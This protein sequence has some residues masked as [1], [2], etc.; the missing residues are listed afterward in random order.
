MHNTFLPFGSQYFRAPTPLRED[1]EKDLVNFKNQGFNTIKIWAQWR[2]NN[3]QEGVYLF[4]DL[5]ELLDLSLQNGIK[6]IINIILDVAPAWFYL[7]YPESIMLQADGNYLVPQVTEYRQVGGAPGPCYHNPDAI[8]EKSL[9]VEELSSKFADHPALLLWDL[10]NEP[11]LTCG[12][13]REAND[14]SMVCY[15]SA[16][17]DSFLKWLKEK[18]K[19]IHFL[20]STWQRNYNNFDEV[21]LPRNS[22][23]FRD[24]ID[25]RTFF[26]DTLAADLKNRVDSVK[27]FDT[28]HPVMIHTVPPPYFNMINAC[29]DDYKM[30][31]H[32]DLFGNSI[33]SDPFPVA[34]SVSSAKGKEVMNAEIHALGGETFNRPGVATYIDFKRHIFTPFARG[35]KGFLFWQYRPELLGRESPAWGLTSLNGESTVYLEYAQQINSLLQSNLDIVANCKPKKSKIAIIKDNNNEIFAW[36]ATNSS[37][38]YTSTLFGAFNAFYKLNYNVDILCT[39][40]IVENGLDDYLLVYYPL[41]YY[42]SIDVAD[43]IKC[44][45]EN[46]G[47]FVSEAFFGGYR[48]ENGL[49]STIL[50]GYGFDEVFG[51]KEFSATSASRFIA[52]YGEKWWESNDDLNIATINYEDGEETFTLNGYFFYEE[53]KPETGKSIGCFQNKSPAIVENNYGAGKAILVGTLLGSAYEKTKNEGTLHF[54]DLIAK[55]AKVDRFVTVSENGIRADILFADSGIALVINNPTDFKGPFSLTFSSTN[56][57]LHCV[58]T[59]SGRSIP[60]NQLGS[61]VKLAMDIDAFDIRFCIIK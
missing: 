32:C 31:K 12:I 53:L 17:R 57:I 20:N 43:T 54:F 8:R 28:V 52:A 14:K 60:F 37:D 61:V 21:E 38:K 4:D 56:P 18:Y 30:A 36:C 42:M 15:C 19:T 48:A 39:D 27:K 25:W 44:W 9:F 35:I 47:V 58:D 51:A 40:Q 34:L 5:Q 49:H 23:T 46:G 13:A 50:P 7:K 22:R 45:I 16:T 33:A 41:P 2:T 24:M 26:A 11:E 10:W 55:K 3:P 29:C 1:W 59:E 6:V